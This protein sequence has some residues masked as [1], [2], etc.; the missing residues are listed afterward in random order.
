V[1]AEAKL[2]QDIARKSTMAQWHKSAVSGARD[3]PEGTASRLAKLAL[4]SSFLMFSSIA[5][6]SAV[7]IETR[8]KAAFA[9]NSFFAA[10][11]GPL[12]P[13]RRSLL[14]QHSCSPPRPLRGEP[15]GSAGLAVAVAP[16]RTVRA[17]SHADIRAARRW[18]ARVRAV[19]IEEPPAVRERRR[20]SPRGPRVAG[21][22]GRACA[23]IEE[24]QADRVCS[25]SGPEPARH[26]HNSH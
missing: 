5:S 10:S 12:R 20:R 8:C 21:S 4:P 17:S 9:F 2:N 14:S 3:A 11:I 26:S 15:S 25:A 24:P 23:G 7:K 13:A 19:G 18:G 16:F 6:A 1:Y 22:R